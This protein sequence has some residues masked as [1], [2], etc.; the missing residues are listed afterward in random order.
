SPVVYRPLFDA[1]GLVTCRTFET[2]A[3]GTLPL[4]CQD[5]AFVA[6]VY[7]DEAAALVLPQERPED[8]VLDLL[9]RPRHYARM[10]EGVRRRLAEK[11]SYAVRLQELIRIVES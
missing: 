6:E 3:A 10:V 11:H 1:L 5:V 4:F 8:K 7:G 2:P 9:R